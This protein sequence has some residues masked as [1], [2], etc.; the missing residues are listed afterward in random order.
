M[1]PGFDLLVY[2]CEDFMGIEVEKQRLYL[3]GEYCYFDDY[4]I[5][6]MYEGNDAAER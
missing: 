5:I 2:Y 1:K 3:S 4:L 6:A